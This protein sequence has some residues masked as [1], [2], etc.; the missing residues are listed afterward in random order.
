MLLAVPAEAATLA[1][2]VGG[3]TLVHIDTEDRRVVRTVKVDGPRDLVGIDVRPG[4]RLLYGVTRDGSVMV[5]DATTG[6]VTPRPKLRAMVPARAMVTV[7]FD[8]AGRLRLIGSDGAN[9]SADVD[10]GS[11]HTGE[12]LQGGEGAAPSILAAAHGGDMLYDIDGSS[13]RLL[14][15]AP[16]DAGKLTPVGGLGITVLSPV[17]FDIAPGGPAWLLT[18]GMLYTVDLSTGRA[19]E[20]GK[21]AG[22]TGDVIDIAVLP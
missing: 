18:G 9:L 21:I 7:D 14:R 6:A 2:L 8:P 13:G 3:D 5:L 1:A 19:S 20:A 12:R 17:A 15:Q 11:V 22:L 10:D 16:P 4:D